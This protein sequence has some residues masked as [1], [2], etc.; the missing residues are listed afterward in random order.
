MALLYQKIAPSIVKIES[1][2]FTARQLKKRMGENILQV[3]VD[4]EKVYGMTSV[5][6]GVGI[7]INN[8]IWVVEVLVWK[9][10]DMKS[11]FEAKIVQFYHFQEMFKLHQLINFSE[12]AFPEDIIVLVR[13]S[14][15]ASFHRH[16]N[17]PIYLQNC[18][19]LKLCNPV[20]INLDHCM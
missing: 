8:A 5:V 13:S 11:Y 6:D 7:W 15:F 12:V 17:V 19:C 20:V 16:W 14:I 4:Y 18:T 1:K 2:E 9:Q 10:F 3:I